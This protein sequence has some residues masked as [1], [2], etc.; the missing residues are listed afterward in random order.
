MVFPI[1]SKLWVEEIIIIIYH[2]SM[3]RLTGSIHQRR[4]YYALFHTNKPCKVG[5]LFT[6]VSIFVV[7]DGSA[8]PPRL[9]EQV[10]I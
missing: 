3:I 4:T 8:R 6:A 7:L 5:R 9:I 1:E 10:L 2:N